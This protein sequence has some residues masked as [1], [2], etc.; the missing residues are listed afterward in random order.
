[1]RTSLARAAV[2]RTQSL[3]PDF[4]VVGAAEARYVSRTKRPNHGDDRG[5]GTARSVARH[6]RADSPIPSRTPRR[7]HRAADRHYGAVGQGLG[8][9]STVVSRHVQSVVLTG[10]LAISLSPQTV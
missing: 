4:C 1:M 6:Q 9:R 8:H 10:A 3:L 7:I 5:D 2:S